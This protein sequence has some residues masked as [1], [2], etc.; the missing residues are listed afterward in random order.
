MLPFFDL[1]KHDYNNLTET[2]E[3][4]KAFCKIE[5]IIENDDEVLTKLC[6]AL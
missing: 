2:E 4:Y 3:V 1:N 5:D 6:V